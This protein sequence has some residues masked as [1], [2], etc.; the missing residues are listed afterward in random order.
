MAIL[1]SRIFCRPV[2]RQNSLY[3][4]SRL[5][6]RPVFQLQ[7]IRNETSL[8]HKMVNNWR[9]LIICIQETQCRWKYFL[10]QRL[11]TTSRPSIL[12]PLSP[13]FWRGWVIDVYNVLLVKFTKQQRRLNLLSLWDSN[14]TVEL[15]INLYRYKNHI[16][17]ILG[18]LS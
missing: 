15:L 4:A 10:F 1:P 9:S 8:N 12:S 7:I 2:S 13:L 16:Y 17:S 11:S 14:I 18:D 3:A 6:C 5:F